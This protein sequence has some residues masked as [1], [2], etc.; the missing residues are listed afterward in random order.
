[1]PR[2]LPPPS[3]PCRSPMQASAGVTLVELL[4]VMAIAGTL[5]ALSV[6]P[7][8]EMV[9]AQKAITTTNT[10]LASLHHT[11]SEAIKRN[12]RVVL[13]KSSDGQSCNEAG[14]WDQGWIVFHD[15]D[16]DGARDAGLA[17]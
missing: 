15:A 4:L 2:P 10:F 3:L 7:L 17:F 6:P 8:A 13:C 11:R 1:M 12:G 5:A 9:G 14:Q 16:N